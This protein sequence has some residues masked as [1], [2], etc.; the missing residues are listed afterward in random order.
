MPIPSLVSLHIRS[1]SSESELD[2]VID[3]QSQGRYYGEHSIPHQTKKRTQCLASNK[4]NAMYQF[5]ATYTEKKEHQ[6]ETEGAQLKAK[7]IKEEG[8]TSCN[9]QS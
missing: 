6:T 4:I 1:F 5:E 3:K 2:I 9:K 8:I 7:G